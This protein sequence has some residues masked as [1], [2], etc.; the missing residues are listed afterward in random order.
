MGVIINA[1]KRKLSKYT[2]VRYY[3]LLRTVFLAGIK[4]ENEHGYTKV[5]RQKIR[6]NDAKALMGMYNEII[7]SDHYRFIPKQEKPVIID[8]GSNIGISLLYFRNLFPDA[9]LV[10]VEADPDISKVLKENLDANNCAATI[11][12]KALW[13]NSGEK[14][15]FGQEGADSGSVFSS[16]NEITVDTINLDDLLSPYDH[17]D[18]LKIDIEGAEVEVF[19]Q[20]N[21]SLDK[22]DYAFI[23]FHS[24]PDRPQELEIILAAMASHGFRYKI[25]PARKEEKPFLKSEKNH[26]MDV[27]LNVFFSKD[28]N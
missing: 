3:G 26:A 17:V 20:E 15:S 22:V 6:Y 7:Y 12:E 19:K 2:D 21:A 1:L 28:L 13:S 4:K 18:L 10:G 11:I 9:T 5:M 23:E 27:Q 16:S 14:L 24:F 25:L 8:C